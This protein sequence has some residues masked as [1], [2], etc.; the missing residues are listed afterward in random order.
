MR[1]PARSNK[2]GA[3]RE[4]R[5]RAEA[6]FLIFRFSLLLYPIIRTRPAI[7]LQ[8]FGRRDRLLL[9]G[10][11]TTARTSAVLVID[12]ILLTNRWSTRGSQLLRLALASPPVQWD[13][14]RGPEAPTVHCG[15]SKARNTAQAEVFLRRSY[16]PLS[17][18]SQTRPCLNRHV[19]CLMRARPR[20]RA[21]TSERIPENVGK[22]GPGRG[23]NLQFRLNAREGLI[24]LLHRSC[25]HSQ[26][27]QIGEEMT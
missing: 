7:G 15:F 2:R 20:T 23:T 5:G 14:N 19:A 11:L 6:I 3:G 25:T 4:P 22:K 17:A 24:H 13:P 18:I 21:L 16:L 26:S 10:R 9:C 12:A 1:A 27:G 8:R